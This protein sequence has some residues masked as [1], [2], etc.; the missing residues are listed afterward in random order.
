MARSSPASPAIRSWHSRGTWD[1]PCTSGPSH[2]R[3]FAAQLASGECSELFACGTA[4]IVSPIGVLADADGTEY[5]PQRVDVVAG[6][7]RDA[8]LAIQE[9]RAPDPFGWTRTVAPFA[10]GAKPAASMVE[11]G[12]APWHAHIYYQ[13]HERERAVQLNARLAMLK[14]SGQ[15]PQLAFI[16][17]LR[18]GKVG[19]HPVPQFEIHFTQELVPMIR[20]LAQESGLT[21]LVHPLTADDLADHT[22]L[23]HWVG[24]PIELDLSVLDPPGTNQGSRASG[25]ATSSGASAPAA[26][27]HRRRTAAAMRSQAAARVRD[28]AVR[29]RF[30]RTRHPRS[31]LPCP[32]NRCRTGRW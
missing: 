20:S 5:A 14:E 19:P 9:R 18:D 28:S 7:L 29:Y 10:A 24:A 13:P 3:I 4:A 1:T 2:S 32:G 25:R 30:R 11:R 26:P 21:T 22:T 8:L 16:G 27:G 31:L 15:A 23:G 6:R 17:E 12:G